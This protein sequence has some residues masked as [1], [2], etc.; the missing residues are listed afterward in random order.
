MCGTESFSVI[1]Y[2][3]FAP[4]QGEMPLICVVPGCKN[5][6][7]NP[8]CYELEW[9]RLPSKQNPI[10]RRLISTTLGLPNDITSTSTAPANIIGPLSP[11]TVNHLIYSG[12]KTDPSCVARCKPQRSITPINEFFMMPVFEIFSM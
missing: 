8:D 6:S 3:F 10:K 9:H 2:F 5:N 7:R 12:S 4:M 1:M 11:E